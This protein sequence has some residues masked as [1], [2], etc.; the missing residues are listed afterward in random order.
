[1]KA[2]FTDLTLYAVTNEGVKTFQVHSGL[3]RHFHKDFDMLIGP[4]QEIVLCDVSHR[5]LRCFVEF[6]YGKETYLDIS[7][8]NNFEEWL[9]LGKIFNIPRNKYKLSAVSLIDVTKVASP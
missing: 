3:L 8:E 4:S 7:A 9:L 5:V 2:T 1:M 6:L